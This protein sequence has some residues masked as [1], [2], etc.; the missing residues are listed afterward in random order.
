MHPFITVEPCRGQGVLLSEETSNMETFFQEM[1]HGKKICKFTLPQ[2]EENQPKMEESFIF[3]LYSS[4][5]VNVLM[6]GKIPQSL[7]YWRTL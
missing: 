5:I 7:C 2:K 6:R 4:R 1:F 3:Q